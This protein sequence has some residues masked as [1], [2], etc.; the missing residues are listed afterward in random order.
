MSLVLGTNSG[1]V[2]SA[3]TADPEGIG[4]AIDANARVTKHTSPAGATNITEVGW[5]RDTGTNTANWE[6]GLY[7]A[8]GATVPGE[9]GTRLYVD[10]S[11]SSSSGGWLTVTVDWTITENTVY[12][13]G[14]QMDAHAGSSTIDAAASGG[15]GIDSLT[16]QNTLPNP[17]G[18]GALLDADGMYAIYAL[19][20]TA[21]KSINVFDSVN[22]SES[23]IA[24]KSVQAINVYDSVNVSEDITAE[25]VASV[26]DL[27]IDVYSSVNVSEDYLVRQRHYGSCGN[28]LL[29]PSFETGSGW[30]QGGTT[31]NVT[32]PSTE[33]AWDGSNSLK[34]VEENGNCYAYQDVNVYEGETLKLSGYIYLS[35]YTDGGLWVKMVNTSWSGYAQSSG[36]DTTG[37]WQRVDCSYTVGAG[38]TVVRVVL[39]SYS[40]ADLT[41]YFDSIMLEVSE[42]VSEFCPLTSPTT[43]EVNVFDSVNVIED[44]TIQQNCYNTNV[45]DSVNVSES[46]TAARNYHEVNV[47]DSV[48]ASED[49]TILQTNYIV[50]VFDSATVAEDITT[51]EQTTVTDL[52][53]SDIYDSVSVSEN[54]TSQVPTTFV[55]VFNSVVV[56]ED[57][58]AFKNS[59]NIDVFDSLTVT[60]NIT[61]LQANLVLSVFDGVTATEDLTTGTTPKKVNIY[62]GVSVSEDVS[63][64]TT[65]NLQ[66]NVN[67]SVGISEL[68]LLPNFVFV[69][70]SQFHTGSGRL[71]FI[72]ANN[73]PLI[74]NEYSTAELNSFFAECNTDGI[75]VVRCWTF[76]KSSEPTNS[77]GFNRY[78]SGGELLWR[79]EWFTNLDNVLDRARAYGVKIVLTLVDNWPQYNNWGP[80]QQYCYWSNEI[81]STVY[82][83]YNQ[84]NDFFLDSNIKAWFKEYIAK[85]AARTN[86]VNGVPYSQDDTIFSW[87]LGNELRLDTNTDTDQNTTSSYRLTTMTAWRDEI[88]D[89][90][91]TQDPNHLVGSGGIDQFYDWVSGDWVHNGTY[92]G[93]DYEIQHQSASVS[94]DY[95][96]FHQYAYDDDFNLRTYGCYD[97]FPTTAT[98]EGWKHQ[99]LD[100]VN[101]AKTNGKPIVMGEWGVNKQ[102]ETENPL[103]AYPK[104]DN[105]TILFNK[106]FN[107]DGD[108]IL[109]WHYTN[110]FDDNNYNIKPDGVHTG[111]YANSNDNDDDS[112][113]LTLIQSWNSTFPDTPSVGPDGYNLVT[114]TDDITIQL[115]SNPQINVSDSVNISE[116]ITI[117]QAQ[118]KIGVFDS[119]LVSEDVTAI[120]AVFIISV[121]DSLTV[122]EDITVSL[123]TGGHSA[124]VYDSINISESITGITNRFDV[125]VYDSATV[126]DDTT[127]STS[128]GNYEINVYNSATVTENISISTEPKQISVYDGISVSES[129]TATQNATYWEINTY[130]GISVSE[131]IT[132]FIDNLYIS[133][134]DSIT[135]AENLSGLHLGGWTL[136]SEAY[137]PWT[138]TSDVS[139]TWSN[140]ADSSTPWEDASE[141]TVT[142]TD[143]EDVSSIWTIIDSE[144]DN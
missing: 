76:N 9:A 46:I 71:R 59:H 47:F 134:Y 77:A 121:F 37:S 49:I 92:Y 111:E 139:S 85:L 66:L 21:N 115:S 136:V 16:T 69:A 81:Y 89:Y 107:Q 84:G 98:Y 100:Y 61:T 137:V 124:N 80:K 11:N 29:D 13:L 63:A 82:D 101:I 12:W 36:V 132:T 109:L 23:V 78:L 31:A 8:D 133:T 123:F 91:K 104:E 10:N 62:D 144:P 75:K 33:Q 140:S 86:T 38:V 5:W 79:E 105:H 67:D 106:F 103:D 90:I 117:Q 32:Y 22:V 72:G 130:E 95:F 14:V 48:N 113:L 116:D 7:A 97:G 122:S 24:W 53:I 119:V 41:G 83:R 26:T 1:F 57:I 45:Y 88:A 96:D 30:T 94:V 27:E 125:S 118:F 6:I 44:V 54:T 40:D 110:L 4:S 141:S 114:V 87:E 138:E 51:E 55:N 64:S 43:C 58:S 68:A 128:T 65:E 42:S 15:A 60:E 2:T 93:Q 129:T 25:E 120:E 28:L 127:V 34:V 126:T 142:W 18:G 135:V 73:Y 112:E 108:G 143:T 52:D 131:D 56:T 19:V 3:P 74:Q 20:E 39:D 50:S 102:N 17:F 70:D 35:S 99:L